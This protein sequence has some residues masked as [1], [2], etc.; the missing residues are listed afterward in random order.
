MKRARRFWISV[1]LVAIAVHVVFCIQAYAPL[2]RGGMV[3]E[4]RWLL[5]FYPHYMLDFFLPPAYPISYSGNGMVQVDYLNFWGKMLVAF[6]AS[7]VRGSRGR[8]CSVR[9]AILGICS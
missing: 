2:Q 6:P 9:K 8:S 4:G 5:V 7:V 3:S 1:G